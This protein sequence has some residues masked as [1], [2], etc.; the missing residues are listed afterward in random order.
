MEEVPPTSRD[1]SA[2]SGGARYLRV[3]SE[4][5]TRLRGFDGFAA[6]VREVEEGLR[7]GWAEGVAHI[8]VTK[9]GGIMMEDGDNGDGGCGW[10]GGWW[11]GGRSW[12]RRVTKTE[13]RLLGKWE[14]PGI[15]L[16]PE[17]KCC[18]PIGG[19]GSCVEHRFEQYLGGLRLTSHRSKQG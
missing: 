13:T 3:S 10:G 15:R 8:E 7:E 14:C 1:S 5:R 19:D 12:S 11:S 17:I 2:V 4:A 6:R 18:I 16:C 9:A